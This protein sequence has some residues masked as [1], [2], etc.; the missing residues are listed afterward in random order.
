MYKYACI[1]TCTHIMFLIVC[2]TSFVH[3]VV[4]FSRTEEPQM[5]HFFCSR[6]RCGTR[7]RALFWGW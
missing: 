4:L 2:V 5:E 6:T 7:V 3:I 1:Y